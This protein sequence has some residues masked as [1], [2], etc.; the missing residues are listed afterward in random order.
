MNR[1]LQQSAKA[2]DQQKRLRED[3]GP[4]RIKLKEGIKTLSR[5]VRMKYM[6]FVQLSLVL[7][8]DPPPPDIGGDVMKLR[9][10]KILPIYAV[11]IFAIIVVSQ[12]SYSRVVC[13]FLSCNKKP[14]DSESFNCI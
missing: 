3:L 1:K 7:I 6:F 11:V 5:Q 14:Q 2:L 13:C 9:R 12:E 8:V 4:Q 10:L